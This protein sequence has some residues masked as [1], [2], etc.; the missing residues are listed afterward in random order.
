MLHKNLS[1]LG[2]VCRSALTKVVH[3]TSRSS[4]YTPKSEIA[5]TFENCAVTNLMF[6]LNEREKIR[7]LVCQVCQQPIPNSMTIKQYIC[8]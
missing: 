7:A 8:R 4:K 6:R 3:R 2:S 1:E 5:E